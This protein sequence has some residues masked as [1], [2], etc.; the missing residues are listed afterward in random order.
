ME[1]I[2]SNLHRAGRAFPIGSGLALVAALALVNGC[3]SEEGAEPSSVE[4]A[5]AMYSAAPVGIWK[6]HKN[7]QPRSIVVTPGPF[8]NNTC[9]IT[10]TE[11]MGSSSLFCGEDGCLPCKYLQDLWDCPTR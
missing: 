11:L 6:C 5:E 8:G 9:T 3:A 10:A 1:A 4:A 2:M 7:L